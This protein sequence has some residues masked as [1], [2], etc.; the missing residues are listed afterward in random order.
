[1]FWNHKSNN[2]YYAIKLVSGIND[3]KSL[4]RI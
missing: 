3:Q 1:M 4:D 2:Y